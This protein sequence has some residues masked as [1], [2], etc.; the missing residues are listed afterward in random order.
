M[1]NPVVWFVVLAAAGWLWSQGQLTSTLDAA[2]GVVDN[3]VWLLAVV[4][5]ALALTSP[6]AYGKVAAVLLGGLIIWAVAAPGLSP[7]LRTPN[8]V[9]GLTLAGSRSGDELVLLNVRCSPEGARGQLVN[10]GSRQAS[11]VIRATFDENEWMHR[12]VEMTVL[13]MGPR[14]RRLW[15][16]RNVPRG[17][18]WTKGCAASISAARYS[19]PPK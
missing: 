5:I 11:L 13:R 9:W 17:A 19:I 10:L 6:G 14:S 7:T 2:A 18:F 8:G 1:R 16:A 3:Y 12:E 4:L 15:T